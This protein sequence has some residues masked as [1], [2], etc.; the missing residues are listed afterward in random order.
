VI[1]ILEREITCKQIAIPTK[2]LFHPDGIASP[3]PA[4][5]GIFYLTFGVQLESDVEFN[6]DPS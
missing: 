4:E 1:A 3:S 6:Q 2:Q 5:T